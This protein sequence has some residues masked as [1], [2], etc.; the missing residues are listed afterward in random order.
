MRSLGVQPI[1]AVVPDNR[2]AQL[3]AGPADSRFWERVRGWQ[4][5]GWFIAMHGWQHRYVT[6]D[7]GLM[8][9]NPRSEF[10]GLPYAEQKAKLEASLAIFR[11]HGVVPDGWVAPGH[12][13]DRITI[14]AL[15]ELGIDVISDGFYPRPVRH[16]GARWLPQQLWRFRDMP[17]GTW[18]VCLHANTMPDAGVA[19]LVNTLSAYRDRICAV[20]EVLAA[21]PPRPGPL[22]HAFRVAW[23]TALRLKQ[24]SAE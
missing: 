6:R 19:Q 10:A 22:D 8:G 4:Q 14:R 23:A 13:F 7:G 11:G 24:R 9:I 20:P 21:A 18:T 3:E 12:S 17:A 16:L 5:A 2:D 1:V 15:L